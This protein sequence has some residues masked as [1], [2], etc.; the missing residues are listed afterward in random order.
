MICIGKPR[1]EG[2]LIGMH[3]S[4]FNLKDKTIRINGLE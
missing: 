1:D 2:E 3:L 4:C